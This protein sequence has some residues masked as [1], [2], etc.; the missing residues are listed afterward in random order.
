MK[1]FTFSLLLV[2]CSLLQSCKM[3]RYEQIDLRLT[4]PN[5][6]LRSKLN[7]KTKDPYV[8]IVHND[9]P[10]D[11]LH[12][13]IQI[14]SARIEDKTLIGAVS[15]IEQYEVKDAYYQQLKNESE[16]GYASTK[17]KRP[18]RDLALNQFHVWVNDS[19]YRSISTDVRIKTKQI[20]TLEKI[21]TFKA[22]ALLIILG[23]LI[24]IIAGFI[25]IDI[26]SMTLT[27]HPE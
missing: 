15:K 24:V 1:A 18:D 10:N 25:I 21:N 23:I 12:Q 2:A 16:D 6:V 13:T 11:T 17:I 3:L 14:Q 8:V 7:K 27:W 20:L 5:S 19:I 4:N 9:D 22:K 26:Q